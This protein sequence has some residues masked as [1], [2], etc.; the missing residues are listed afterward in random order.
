MPPVLTIGKN[1]EGGA[2]HANPVRNFALPLLAVRDA[3]PVAESG[4]PA[5]FGISVVMGVLRLRHPAILSVIL[6][7]PKERAVGTTGPVLSVRRWNVS[8]SESGKQLG[9]TVWRMTMETVAAL[10]LA[11][12]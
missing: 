1:Q 5:L 6:R 12:W 2:Q 10:K 9:R 4:L 7:K 8:E 11:I 3:R